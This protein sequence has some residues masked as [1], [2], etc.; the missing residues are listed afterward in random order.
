MKTCVVR[1]IHDDKSAR[2]DLCVTFNDDKLRKPFLE[3][4]VGEG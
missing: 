4:Y 3:M 2:K 1:I